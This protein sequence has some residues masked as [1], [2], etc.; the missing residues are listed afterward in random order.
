MKKS[1]G[2]GSRQ[3]TG[4]AREAAE[5]TEEQGNHS[6]M[7]VSQVGKVGK[8]STPPLQRSVFRRLQESSDLDK[9]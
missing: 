4:S 6:N 7:S 3:L 2:D 9:A 1:R 8:R 5:P